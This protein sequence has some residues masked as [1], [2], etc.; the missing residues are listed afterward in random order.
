[1]P[2]PNSPQSF[3]EAR[4]EFRKQKKKQKKQT[5]RHRVSKTRKARRQA[6][7]QAI[8]KL[9]HKIAKASKKKKKKTKIAK[10]KASKTIRCDCGDKSYTGSELTPRGLG[11]CEEC[12]LENVILRGADGKLYRNTGDQES[13]KWV[14]VL[15]D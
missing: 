10:G 13:R 14:K 3:S 9:S 15:R 8:S 1:M 7:R 12:T 4:K 5:K 2:A 6:R 11:H